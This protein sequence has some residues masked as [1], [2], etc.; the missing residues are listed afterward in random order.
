M[1]K[2]KLN[3]LVTFSEEIHFDIS[4]E[5]LSEESKGN[6]D[7]QIINFKENSAKIITV[8]LLDPRNIKKSPKKKKTL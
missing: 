3:S 2:L 5:T 6:E 1:N 4:S 7:L 8:E